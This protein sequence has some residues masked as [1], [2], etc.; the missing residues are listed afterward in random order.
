MRVHLDTGVFSVNIGLFLTCGWKSVGVEGQPYVLILVI[1]YRA[2]V[3][4]SVRG[5]PGTNHSQMPRDN[6][7]FGGVKSGTRIFDCFGV[8]TPTL[9]LSKGRLHLRFP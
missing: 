4:F 1:L 2:S 5:S 8:G 9:A 6:L 3:A 7:S